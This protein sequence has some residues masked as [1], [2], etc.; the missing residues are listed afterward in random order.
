[1]CLCIYAGMCLVCEWVCCCVCLRVFVRVCVRICVYVCV[2]VCVLPPPSTARFPLLKSLSLTQTREELERTIQAFLDDLRKAAGAAQR[3]YL[4]LSVSCV[5]VCMWVCVVSCVCRACA[6]VVRVCVVC[7]MY[8]S[9]ACVLCA[10]VLS[11]CV[12]CR[13]YV[14]R[15]CAVSYTRK[16]VR[17]TL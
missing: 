13:M 4:C 7:R 3:T 10:R 1:M 12:V 14:C 6:C 15:V 2:C 8:V 5:F 11:V 16:C 9:C 17:H